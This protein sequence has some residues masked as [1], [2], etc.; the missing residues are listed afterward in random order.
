M[1]HLR[2]MFSL[3]ILRKILF[4]LRMCKRLA[5]CLRN[6]SYLP[7]LTTWSIFMKLSSKS[8]VGNL[9]DVSATEQLTLGYIGKKIFYLFPFICLLILSKL[10]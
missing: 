4:Y 5:E 9:L 7:A 3:F 6:M 10:S 1:E 2:L 8:R